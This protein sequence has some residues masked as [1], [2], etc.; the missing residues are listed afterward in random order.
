MPLF[1]FR[2]SLCSR[3]LF[4]ASNV[5]FFVLFFAKRKAEMLRAEE[6]GKEE[7][8]WEGR[9]NQHTVL[10]TSGC[11]EALEAEAFVAGRHGRRRLRQ[12]G[13]NRQQEMQAWQ[14]GR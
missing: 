5:C 11:T 13:R 3:H 6:E 9:S 2:R 14:R 7:E 10:H 12:G 4:T 8:E 1:P